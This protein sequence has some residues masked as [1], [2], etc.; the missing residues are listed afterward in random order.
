M[1]VIPLSP[2][3]TFRTKKYNTEHNKLYLIIHTEKFCG[4]TGIQSHLSDTKYK[5]DTHK[6]SGF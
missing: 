6:N 5:N 1:P 2:L 4:K 3:V